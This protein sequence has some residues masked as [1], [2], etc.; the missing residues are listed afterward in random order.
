MLEFIL[1][2]PLRS[3]IVSPGRAGIEVDANPFNGYNP[4]LR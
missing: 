1:P 4:A 2:I 3:S